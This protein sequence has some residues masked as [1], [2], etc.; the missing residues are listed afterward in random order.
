VLGEDELEAADGVF[1]EVGAAGVGV[2]LIAA[3]AVGADQVA[4][5]VEGRVDRGVG[6]DEQAR[7]AD[8]GLRGAPVAPRDRRALRD[9]P[10]LEAE[11]LEEASQA[12]RG[13]ITRCEDGGLGLGTPCR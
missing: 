12:A 7:A 10:E 6:P 11:G 3:G 1:F 2:D 8:P 9:L 4:G 13:Q 5:F